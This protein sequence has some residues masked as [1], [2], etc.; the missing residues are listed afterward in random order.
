MSYIGGLDWDDCPNIFQ[1]HQHVDPSLRRMVFPIMVKA[2]AF[3]NLIQMTKQERTPPMTSD[4]TKRQ[5]ILEEAI[6][7]ITADRE[8]SY[9]APEDS[10]SEI[11]EYWSVYL[12]RANLCPF[13]RELD[14]V[15]VA[16]MMAL[17]KL[18]RMSHWHKEDNFVDAAGY[19]AIA[20]ELGDGHDTVQP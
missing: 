11:A 5:K 19:I 12:R 3:P 8:K 4:K 13:D 15:D 17:L 14:S 16:K 18:A 10:F 6:T 1:H 7:I 9:G 20:G 2:F